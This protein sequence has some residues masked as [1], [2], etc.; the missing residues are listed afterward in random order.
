M[1]NQADNRISCTDREGSDNVPPFETD[2]RRQA[3]ERREDS[4]E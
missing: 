4:K 1:Y 3:W 2:G